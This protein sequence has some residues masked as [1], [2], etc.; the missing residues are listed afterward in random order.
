VVKLSRFPANK[1]Q[2]VLRTVDHQVRCPYKCQD[3]MEYVILSIEVKR[4]GH[5]CLTK[6]VVIRRVRGTPK[7]ED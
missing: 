3:I 1:A 7:A 4:L 6:K 5:T 2:A